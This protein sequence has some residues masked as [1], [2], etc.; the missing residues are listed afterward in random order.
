MSDEFDNLWTQTVTE[1]A[2]PPQIKPHMNGAISPPLIPFLPNPDKPKPD[3][4]WIDVGCKH[5]PTINAQ[6]WQAIIKHN[7]PPILF[8]Y[9]NRMVHVQENQD[10]TPWIEPISPEILMNLL[11]KWANW[12]KGDKGLEFPPLRSI[13]DVI[14]THNGYLNLPVLTRLVTT[15]V[16]CKKGTL[17]T[18]PGYNPESGVLYMP[19]KDFVALPVPD[20]VKIEDVNTANQLICG[21][22]L[23]DFPF[24]SEADRDNAIALMVLPVVRDM[25]EGPTPNHIVESSMNGSG[26]GKLV[27][28]LLY[29][30][31]G[32]KISEAPDP[33]DE[34][35]WRKTITAK[36]KENRP[37]I[38]FDNISRKL[39]SP[40]LAAAIT[41]IT[42]AD[43]ILGESSTPEFT[44]RA[45][46]VTTGTNMV[47]HTEQV[48]RAIRIR[49]TPKTDRPEQRPDEEFL[50][51]DLDEW[52]KANRSRLLQAIHII[53]KF[54][55]QQNL[56]KT[57][58]KLGSFERWGKVIG[59]ILHSAGYAKFLSNHR[60][61]Q[62]GADIDRTARASLCAT[63]FDWAQIRKEAD[64]AP[65]LHRVG[66]FMT[67][68]LLVLAENIDGLVI[69]GN[70]D[71]ARQT[72][73]GMYL[74][75]NVDVI[76][77]F[78]EEDPDSKYSE[79]KF[80]IVNAGTEKGRQLWSVECV[81]L[82]PR[83]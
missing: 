70:S 29:P 60:D 21:E 51:P 78:L 81:E 82:V 83:S 18:T 69:K 31:V 19:A 11:S 30:S 14:A 6:C 27:R 71:K 9:E 64:G 35:E 5:D 46:W 32:N 61:F 34:T 33:A 72:A 17:Q 2:Q 37:V 8:N 62:A 58:V 39:D 65:L 63:W 49:L 50:H 16:F 41:S 38:L 44:V 7:N 36:I 42:W 53:C 22:L 67:T 28:A 15:P 26:K 77:S 74:K 56:P 80:R 4:I 79:R 3:E 20:E 48:R 55:I 24:S 45:I 75:N 76:A 1:D 10:G 68:E 52:V 59:S 40:S 25:I 54:A 57:S 13:K 43:R 23:R 73:F 66:K 47:L 12:C